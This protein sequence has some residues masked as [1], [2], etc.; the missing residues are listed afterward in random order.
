MRRS[1]SARDQQRLA[2]RRNER[3]E[4]HASARP[5]GHADHAA[6]RRRAPGSRRAAGVTSRPREA[7]SER[8]TAISFWRMKARAISRFATLAHAIS[9][10]RPTMHISTISAVEKSLRRFEKP[11]AAVLDEQLPLHELIARVLR[12]VL[13]RRQ[14][15]LVRADL[16]EETLQRRLRGFDRVARLQAAEH[17]HPARPPVVQVHPRPSRASSPA[18]SG[19]ARG[20]AARA[21]GRDRR[22][23][24]AD[25][26]TMVIG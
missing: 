12:P 18:S 8:R 7:P 11:I 22:N 2:F 3:Q 6:E 20:C 25:T 13:R 21:P 24:S 9:S 5:R 23:P 10:T 26:P 16:G 1:G 15:H 17:L 4:R 14:R 19:S